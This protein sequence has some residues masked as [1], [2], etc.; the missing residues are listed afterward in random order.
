MLSYY[1][2]RTLAYS[3]ICLPIILSFLYVREFGVNVP[4]TDMWRMVPYFEK[5]F[6]GELGLGDLWE[7]HS[8]EHR[9]LLPRV[10]LLLAGPLANFNM[11]TIMY[12]TQLCLLAIFGG[13][14]L[15]YRDTLGSDT[16]SLFFAIPLSL[17]VFSTSQYWNILHAWSIHVVVVNSFAVLSFLLL[18]RLRGK[19]QSKVILMFLVAILGG[20]AATLSAGHGL[21][22][23]PVG[24]I[25]LL[26]EPISARSKKYLLSFWGL[27]G[28]LH[29]IIYFI[30][31][32]APNAEVRTSKIY[33]FNDLSG[34]VDFF[35]GLSGFSLFLN[36]RIAVITG[37]IILALLII[38]VFQIARYREFGR[39]TF[40]LS[41]SAFSLLTLASTTVGRAGKGLD[42]TT[43]SKYVT[44]SV[45]LAI[46]VYVMALK[47]SQDH[48]PSEFS[49]L[50]LGGF[51][52]LVFL[53][54]PLSYYSSVLEAREIR[55]EREEK[56]CML[57]RYEDV[58]NKTLQQT[59]KPL[60]DRPE[61]GRE[62]RDGA[63]VLDDLDYTIFA[64]PTPEAESEFSCGKS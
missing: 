58:S 49:T 18:S 26:V 56:A 61:I 27:I 32:E 7:K 47:L 20:S 2:I 45:L 5:F 1:A 25:Q 11:M 21:M 52:G 64:L 6:G 14:F 41:L 39:H 60:R 12:A 9:P 57:I 43:H 33:V 10:F 3:L 40:W 44:F 51:I 36:S 37:S 62:I 59:F 46:G 48:S 35:L 13:I 19:G 23:W 55:A 30:N 29:W 16:K 8:G 42:G 54:A 50:I 38:V 28:T 63:T 53:S 17:F 31:F 34:G 24:L 22:I 4:F 15:A